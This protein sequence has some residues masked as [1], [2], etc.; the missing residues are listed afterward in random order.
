M[1]KCREPGLPGS[2]APESPS[3]RVP[4]GTENLAHRADGAGHFSS[5]F[6]QSGT[7]HYCDSD[8][9][10]VGDI[11]TPKRERC[12]VQ[13]IPKKEKYTHVVQIPVTERIHA[14]LA[15]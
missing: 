12:E 9:M 15:Q 2:Q 4:T 14:E 6:R 10:S 11:R 8:K 3:T 1:D 5:L 7:N 13:K